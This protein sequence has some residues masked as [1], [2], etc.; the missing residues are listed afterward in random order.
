MAIDLL[1]KAV[2]FHLQTA[3]NTPNWSQWR[4]GVMFRGKANA[5]FF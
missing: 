2:E 1:A 3:K 4:S 5:V